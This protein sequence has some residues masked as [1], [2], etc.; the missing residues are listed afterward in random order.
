[1]DSSNPRA[2]QKAPSQYPRASS[3][4]SNRSSSHARAA[5]G[6]R[7]PGPGPQFSPS[8]QPPP[9]PIHRYHHS[10]CNDPVLSPRSTPRHTPQL[11][12]EGSVESART[13]AVSTFLQE[14]L[15]R[16]RR[17]ESEKLNQSTLSRVSED[18]GAPVDISRVN[19]PR[20]R[21]V[22]ASSDGSRPK[23]SGG[24]EPAKKPGLGVKD[25]ENVRHQGD[26]MFSGIASCFFSLTVLQVIS[27]LHKQNFDLKLELYHRREKQSSLETSIES[28]QRDKRQ[29]EEMNETLL[30]EL[31][32]RDKAVEEAVAMIVMLE[33]KVDQ[34]IQERNMVMQVEQE[35][36]FCR[37]DLDQK[38]LRPSLDLSID[39][40][41]KQGDNGRAINRVPSFLSEKSENTE[42]LRSVY[43]GVKGSALSLARVTEGNPDADNGPSNGLG[44][45]T[46][47]VLSESSFASVYGKKSQDSIFPPP[48]DQPL[49]LDG[50]D[51]D[52]QMLSTSGR[53][54]SKKMVSGFP[55]RA[56]S[57]NHFLGGNR[58][59]GPRHSISGAVGHASPLQQ[60]EKLGRS[61]SVLQ[62]G[63]RPVANQGR[64]RR[65]SQPPP[66]L[67]KVMTDGPGTMRLHDPNFPP[68]P[69]TISTS[70]LHRMRNSNDSL[71]RQDS[72]N[73]RASTTYSD[74][75]SQSLR[76]SFRGKP[77]PV[78]AADKGM[79]GENGQ[80][81]GI[82]VPMPK[83][84]RAASES[85]TSQ[86]KENRWDSTDSDEQSEVHSLRSS[87]DI[88]M[89]ESNKPTRGANGDVS[90]DL[91]SFPTGQSHGG[92]PSKLKSQGI[93]NDAD[94]I[95]ELFSLRQSL[96]TNTGPPPPGRR[97]SLHARTSSTTSS[98]RNSPRTLTLTSTPEQ[99]EYLGHSRQQSDGVQVKNDF[100]TPLQSPSIPQYPHSE[101]RSNYPPVSGPRTA[102]NRLF[103]RSLAPTSPTST[104]ASAVDAT[105][106]DAFK[107]NQGVS[108]QPWM[109][110]NIEGAFDDRAGATPPP[111]MLKP[112][113]KRRN[114]VGTEATP[115]FIPSSTSAPVRLSDLVVNG[116]NSPNVKKQAAEQS[117]PAP[118]V[119]GTR[120]KWL[121]GF[122]RASSSLR[123]RAN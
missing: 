61:Q 9:H 33:A 90:P 85:T 108:L 63:F 18:L 51:A 72:R 100:H 106:S 32:K 99:D 16:E 49:S 36:Y 55:P 5:A 58:S 47:S 73:D 121:P 54:V 123:N 109:N 68:T 29:T 76:V 66:T 74:Q 39:E 27:S 105:F 96:F 53:D 28:L 46:L 4:T 22:A 35:G 78:R 17:A 42:N 95:N 81:Y 62:E 103:R 86:K 114:T 113:Q 93:G 110:K 87:L 30:D 89:K 122:S 67:R 117:T 107:S 57:A 26:E 118:S 8:P 120:R 97:S 40:A 21:S 115:T 24:T 45:P 20:R 13:Q 44:S 88:W 80:I 31:E 25:M 52:L 50:V 119:I 15:Q 101:K 2:F 19:S 104:P 82:A 3:R 48:V 92:W 38:Y 64:D 98:A 91:F 112:R 116:R 84:Q 56:A 11:S 102:L 14:K 111:I 43:L 12:R 7:S 59:S 69:D 70:T 10:P 1:M 6:V 79:E 60:I 77:N 37:Q 71:A 23:S 83:H 41:A 65:R 34:L 94:Y 75:D